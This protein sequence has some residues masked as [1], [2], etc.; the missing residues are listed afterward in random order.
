MYQILSS[1]AAAAFL[2]LGAYMTGSALPVILLSLASGAAW[3]QHTPGLSYQW[4]AR[5]MVL[6]LA[7]YALALVITLYAWYDLV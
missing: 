7:L 5:V 2:A 4:Q 6:G 1:L 3:I